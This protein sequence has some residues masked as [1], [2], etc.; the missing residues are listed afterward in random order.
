MTYLGAHL[1][2]SRGFFKMGQDALAIGANT[3]QC[4]VRNPRG[5][6]AKAVKP[7]DMAKLRALLAE[8]QFGPFVAHAPYI[9]NPC[10]KD[11]GIR[12]LAGRMMA[13]DLELMEHL[14]GNYYNFHPGSHTGQGVETGCQQ[15]AA[16]LDGA[17][18]PE[19]HTTV[20]LETMAGKGSEIGGRFEELR[21]ILD[22]ARCGERL[23][24]CLD[25]CHISDGGYDIAGDLDGVLEA[26]DRT[27]GLSRLK[28]VHINDSLNPC[29]SHKDRHA[30]IGEGTIGTEAILRVIRHPALEGLPFILETPTD[31]KGHGEE[32]A[33]LRERLGEI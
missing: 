7:E 15:I 9:M 6:R 11:E 19:L 13:E 25:T 24:V 23:G 33:R 5:A 16:M 17:V 12:E 18:K 14:P 26:F 1:S 8:N 21:M 10:S 30:L 29:G 27:V 3:F 32:I 20:L 22:M 2:S 31:D 4:F 28:A